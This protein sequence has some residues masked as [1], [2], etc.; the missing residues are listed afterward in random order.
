MGAL[1]LILAGIS[2]IVVGAVGFYMATR[3]RGGRVGPSGKTG[4]ELASERE[5][6]VLHRISELAA[7]VFWAT[8]ESGEQTVYMSPSARR[9]LGY[10]PDDFAMGR[11]SWLEIVDPRDR[12]HFLRELHAW[13]SRRGAPPLTLEYRITRADGETRWMRDVLTRASESSIGGRGYVGVAMDITAEKDAS[14]QAREL[15]EIVER[16]PDLMA[17]AQPDGTPLFMNSAGCRLLGATYPRPPGSHIRMAHP[18]W[19]WRIV[20]SE[21]IPTAIREGVWV[22]ETAFL[23]VEGREIP[24]HQVIV[25]HR[26]E[27]GQV[28]RLSTIARDISELKR[29]EREQ[30]WMLRELDHRVKNNLALVSAI[31]RQTAAGATDVDAYVGALQTRLKTLSRVHASL[32][33][34]SWGGRWGEAALGEVVRRCLEPFDFEGMGRLEMEGSD[35]PLG[36]REATPI[37]LAVFELAANAAKHGAWSND[38][39]RVHVSWGRR[40]RRATLTWSETQSPFSGEFVEGSGLRLV[41]DCVEGA[42]GGRVTLHGEAGRFEA[43]FSF[44]LRAFGDAESNSLR[45]GGAKAP[46]ANRESIE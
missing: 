14:I 23:T 13:E 39:G 32:S 19:A 10:E 40:G 36:A 44:D 37:G 28:R 15:A 29:T 18:E 43:G 31:A 26:D 27:Q 25:A 30:T 45:G 21:G 46:A 35:V 16:A 3:R 41:R 2:G 42:L 17:I 1:G 9:V 20:E 24:V 5:N 8:D 22:G 11:R 34:G 7:A 33:Q 6:Q 12:E 4:G 38:S